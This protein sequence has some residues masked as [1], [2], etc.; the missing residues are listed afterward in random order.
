MSRVN[1]EK[2]RIV[3]PGGSG[4]VGAILARHF[5]AQGDDVVVVARTAKPSPWK[6]VPWDGETLGAWTSEL[7][8]AD[9][10]INLAG[11]NV[12]CRYTAEN[13]REIKE[14][15][16]RSTRLVGEAIGRMAHP[17]RIWMNASTATIYRHAFDRPMDEVTGEIGGKEP[18]APSTWAFSID[19]AT[20]WE[21][22]F[23]SASTPGTRKVALRSAMV[24]SPDRGGVF[25]TLL[26]LVRFGLGGASGSGKQF[27]SWVHDRDFLRSIDYLAEHE[28]LDGAVNIASPNPVPNAEFMALLRKA[29]GT[30]IGLPAMEWMLEFGAIFLRTETELILKSR[31]VIP[32]RLLAHGFKFDFPEWGGAARDLVERWRNEKR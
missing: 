8:G 14:S 5:H 29:W 28:N 6:T 21:E 13:R 30:H 18:N 15:R 9:L 26:A 19:V 20:S 31:R 27:V 11:R 7:D 17:P 1:Q 10:V 4:Q 22:A 32:G 12:N 3:L 16:V 2:R 23:F 24:M 25:D